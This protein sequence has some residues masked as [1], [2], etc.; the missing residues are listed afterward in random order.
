MILCNFKYFK[1][2]ALEY[3]GKLFWG[4][5]YLCSKQIFTFLYCKTFNY[6]ENSLK[7]FKLTTVKS[8]KLKKKL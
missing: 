3:Q 1:S 7:P 2:L 4:Y 8:L 5:K 6:V